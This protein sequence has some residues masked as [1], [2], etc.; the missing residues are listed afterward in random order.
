[1]PAFCDMVCSSP[2]AHFR[3][4][5]QIGEKCRLSQRE[6]GNFRLKYIIYFQENA[7]SQLSVYAYPHPVI[8]QLFKETF[9]ESFGKPK[10]CHK[11]KKR[12]MKLHLYIHENDPDNIS[13]LNR[14]KRV[15]TKAGEREAN[16]KEK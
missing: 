2:N 16:H 4:S 7:W 10:K 3:R 1:M 13:R 9:L 12:M 6:G 15:D 5:V 11:R 8:G 14:Q